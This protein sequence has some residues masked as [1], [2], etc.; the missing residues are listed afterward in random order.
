MLLIADNAP[1]QARYDAIVVGLGAMGSAALWR[2][3]AQ[4]ASVL[5]IEQFQIGHDRGSSHGGSRIIRFAYFEH[6]DY[7][8]LL[9]RAGELWKELEAGSQHRIVNMCG[10]LYGGRSG[11]EVIAGVKTSARMHGIPLELIAPGDVGARFAA[12][13][14]CRESVDQ[15]VFEPDAGFVRPE[16]AIGRMVALAQ[17]HGA[18]VRTGLRVSGWKETQECVEV[19]CGGEH[20]CCRSLIVTTGPWASEAV[21]GMGVEIVNTRQVIA[22]VTPHDARVCDASV[23]PAFFLERERGAPLYGIPMAN[24]QD[25]PT[26]VKLGMHG[27]GGACTPDTIDRIVSCDEAD[28]LAEAFAIAAPRAAGVVSAT[29]TCMY[30]NTPDDHFVIDRLAG[31]NRI[32]LAVGFCGHG[33]K[34]APVVGEILANRALKVK[35]D[36]SAE[37]LRA[38]RFNST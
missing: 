13:E 9:R 31:S 23:M 4:G 15:F 7:V 2:L 18:H 20:F 1:V 8:P 21:R 36:H 12:F 16:R 6:S 22:W 32:E 29:A 26:G 27:R 33:F 19:D 17:S 30:S 34:F 24:D 5:G 25:A 3:A 35:S 38:L 14:G 37:F 10:V 28:A 11:S